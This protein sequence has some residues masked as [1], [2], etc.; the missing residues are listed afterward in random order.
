MSHSQRKKKKRVLPFSL[1]CLPAATVSQRCVTSMPQQSQKS[2]CVVGD[3]NKGLVKKGSV[4]WSVCRS[5]CLSVNV[6]RVYRPRKKTFI[7]K[8]SI[9]GVDLQLASS[10]FS[11]YKNDST[12]VDY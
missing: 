5:V 8:S 12:S 7:Q 6:Y 2:V 10:C 3:Q 11:I 1:L 4:C 9:L